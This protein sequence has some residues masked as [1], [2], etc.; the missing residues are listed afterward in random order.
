[1][2]TMNK[3]RENTG[4]ILWILVISFGG[5]W[6]LQDSGVFDTIGANPLGKVIVVNGDPVTLEEYQRQLE[7][8]LE[9][10][11][12]Q[13]GNAV[14]PQQLETERERAFTALVN[15]RLLV[16]E[17]DRLGIAV[18]D[19]EIQDLIT[20]E[21]PHEIIRA[22][23]SDQEGG[24]D[25]AILQN[26]IDDPEQEAAWIQI[27]EYIR[28]D[29]RRQ[30]F[31]K[32][33][34]ATVRVSD[35]DIQAAYEREQSAASAEFF[36]LRYAEIPDSS[37]TL[38]DRD[39]S[40][41]YNDHKE[42][43]TKERLYSIE[44]A[45]LSKEPAGEDTLALQREAERLLPEFEV[46]ENDSLFLIQSGSA[47]PYSNNFLR[48]SDFPLS[49]AGRLF[50]SGEVIAPGL[51]VGP[52]TEQGG[53]HL[54]KVRD[55]RPAEETAVRARHILIRAADDDDAAIAS[56]RARIQ[57]LRAR[58]QNG[59]DFAELAANHSDDPGSRDKGGDLGWFGEGVMVQPFEEAAFGASVGT[60][61]G[62]VETQHGVHLIEVTHR[63]ATEVQI[64]H[65]RLPIEASVAT[66]NAVQESLD[67]LRFY[68]E[69]SGD[70][71]GEAERRAI[72]VES[73]QM[74]DGQ[75]FLPSFG[76][77][78]G[79]AR[80]L[81]TAET[82]MISPVI[83]LNEVSLVV[84]VVDI[85]EEGYQPLED[86]EGVI[87]QRALLARKRELQR[88]RLEEAYE[89]GG[90]D[91]LNEALDVTPHS[92]F[93]V[94]FQNQIV[95]DLGR[96]PIFAGTVLGLAEGEDSGVVEGENAVF[97]ARVTTRHEPEPLS[98]DERDRLREQLTNDLEQRLR[99]QWING[100]RDRADIQ[101]LRTDML[102]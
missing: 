23:F 73:L 15:N 95:P 99:N 20:G 100:L 16:R 87:R 32:L 48:A 84:H 43:Y 77:S 7:S 27:E 74:Q 54:I 78:L 69:E 1:M 91:G 102:W 4:I 55:T 82:G 51:V 46:A 39:L 10:V 31:D 22:N 66:L 52:V 85:E 64:A 59:E 98:D 71:A 58:I 101:D 57:E 80:F 81:E 45:S 28:L 41:F 67:D 18:S 49:V 2:G 24:I 65:L 6:V 42:E 44:L 13:T 9:Q 61:A 88:A 60:L 63:A 12:Q 38:A 90:F 79:V 37:I 94:S 40:R 35:G 25:R 5:L 17:M 47:Q 11:R 26:V 75:Q 83:E 33:I 92:A 34:S 97:V 53:V 29:R 62:P 8:Q 86:V 72:S 36:F 30:K 3:M 93:G 19:Q 89:G 96:D 50:E 68:T 70:F 21:N 56:A 76:L 14:E